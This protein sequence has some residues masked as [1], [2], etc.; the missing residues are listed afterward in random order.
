MIYKF[1]VVLKIQ[2]PY[3]YIYATTH[4]N[5]EKS[6]CKQKQNCNCKLLKEKKKLE[7][8]IKQNFFVYFFL[9]SLMPYYLIIN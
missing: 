6:T 7:A 4:H 5:I 2:F 1:F 8:I 9:F 3:S